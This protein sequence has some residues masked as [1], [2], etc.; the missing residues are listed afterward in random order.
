MIYEIKDR[1]NNKGRNHVGQGRGR[2][3]L[4]EEL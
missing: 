2:L 4:A 3:F 1:E